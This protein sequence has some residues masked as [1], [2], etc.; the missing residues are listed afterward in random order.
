MILK[1]ITVAGRT[2]GVLKYGTDFQLRLG[3]AVLK[4]F[5]AHHPEVGQVSPKDAT[6]LAN[7]WYEQLKQQGE[8]SPEFQSVF[9][10]L[11]FVPYG[12]APLLSQTLTEIDERGEDLS[13]DEL[14]AI[15]EAEAFFAMSVPDK[16]RTL[17]SS[18]IDSNA[19]A[20]APAANESP[21]TNGSSTTAAS[22]KS[23][24]RKKRSATLR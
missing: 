2:Y 6:R 8:E 17:A 4:I 22:G 5:L 7:E 16:S 13:M 10:D 11:I 12:G 1:T 15:T 14:L 3:N 23:A 20:S 19:N 18:P 21:T 9:R 24:G